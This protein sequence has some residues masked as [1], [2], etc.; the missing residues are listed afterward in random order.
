[1]VLSL[2]T[3][4][5]GTIPVSSSGRRNGVAVFVGSFLLVFALWTEIEE[6]EADCMQSAP[7]LFFLQ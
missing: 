5:D 1:V 2:S 3:I 7:T 4:D 6:C